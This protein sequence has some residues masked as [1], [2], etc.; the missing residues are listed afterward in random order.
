[1]QAGAQGMHQQEPAAHARIWPSVYSMVKKIGPLLLAAEPVSTL[2]VSTLRR[3]L[4]DLT[5]SLF[6]VHPS[7]TCRLGG[8]LRCVNYL[9]FACRFA[10]LS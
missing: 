3:A 9:N 10:T 2:R 1:M 6:P 5:R 8:L 7:P 4:L